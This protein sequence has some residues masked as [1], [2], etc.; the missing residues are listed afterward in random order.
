MTIQIFWVGSVLT[1]HNKKSKH[2]RFGFN[3]TQTQTQK[4]H[5]QPVGSVSTEH[6][7]FNSILTE[8]KRLNSF[9]T[10]H[11]NIKIPFKRNYSII[12]HEN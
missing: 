6:K 5:F 8:H 7:R 11:T 12:L 10:E 9:S 1:E 2:S 4:I 3:R